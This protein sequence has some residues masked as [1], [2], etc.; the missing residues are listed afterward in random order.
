MRRRA[1]HP[2]AATGR[3]LSL[4]RRRRL[5]GGWAGGHRRPVHLDEA[6]V[7]RRGRLERRGFV[8]VSRERRHVVG[9]RVVLEGR[10]QIGFVRQLVHHLLG[11][12]LGLVHE[13]HRVCGSDKG[14]GAPRESVSLHLSDENAQVHH[15]QVGRHRLA[16]A[17]AL[18]PRVDQR[19]AREEDGHEARGLELVAHVA[20]QLPRPR[21]QSLCPQL[22]LQL[23]RHLVHDRLV[24]LQ[25]QLAYE[26]HR[27]PAGHEREGNS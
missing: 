5:G 10:R 7:L 18:D 16:Q 27:R 1:T 12:C 17:A 19:R 25:P 6:V 2:L 15:R 9:G 3:R 21:L 20:R 4:Q 11:E 14:D 24:A 23:R 22:L 13:R 26:L 8:A